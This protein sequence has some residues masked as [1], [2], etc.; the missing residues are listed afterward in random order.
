MLQYLLDYSHGKKI[1]DHLQFYVSNLTFEL[2][3]G[4]ESALEMLASFF[5]SFPQVCYILLLFVTGIKII[6]LLITYCCSFIQFYLSL[7][8][9]ITYLFYAC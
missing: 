3:S 6:Y 2:E 8:K 5:T 1:K 7:I 4:R 9:N